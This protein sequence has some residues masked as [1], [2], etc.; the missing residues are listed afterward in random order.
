MYLPVPLVGYLCDRYKPAYVSFL[1]SLLFGSG[2][3]LAAWTYRKGPPVTVGGNGWPSAVMFLAFCG[4]GAGTVCMYLSAVTTCA[5]N[6]GRGKYKGL[7]LALP[8]AAFGLSGMWQSQVGS[9]FL[10]ERR[11]DGKRGDVDP[12]QYFI[13]LGILLSVVGVIGAV[14]LRVV[15]EEEMLEEAVEEL[16]R[17]GLLNEHDF[18]SNGTP[19]HYGSIQHV[20][21][22]GLG[23]EGSG[24]EPQVDHGEI[25]LKKAWLLNTE[26]RRFLADRTMWG[27][28]GGF[29]FA[30]GPGE[31]FILNLGT[32]IGTLY[33]PGTDP[34]TMP[35]T[36]ATHVSIVSVT[37]TLVRIVTGALSDLL[38]PTPTHVAH[39]SPALGQ[40]PKRLVV[41]RI[42]FL[43]G[44]ALVQS[45]GQVLLAS[46]LIQTHAERFW[47]V[48]VLIGS[49]Y[50]A[51]FSLTP[52]VCSVIWGVE[53]FGTN[54]GIVTMV[55]AFSATMW[56]LI[57][58]AVYQSAAVARPGPGGEGET[59]TL[60][61]GKECYAAT[62][63]AMALSIWLGCG[64]WVWAWR[65]PGGWS[66]R[67]I[68]I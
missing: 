56:N 14:F 35:T 50:G 54:W 49:G 5:K 3:F 22:P 46:G 57:Y 62:Y 47:I 65:G 15:D 68:A 17:S 58:S 30:I 38:A 12:F 61:Y 7:A 25:R 63:W 39:H 19:K 13:F 67:G 21:T 27:L 45:L 31:S 18:F 2:Y 33:P 28:A 29:F 6:F 1:A 53:N 24:S 34:S 11:Q 44:S 36:A 51:I 60:C 4:V 52:I 9:R 32:I 16:E 41:S 43:L 48:S 42:N 40:E 66:K 55:P 26:T 10:Y 64:V 20:A 23:A 8:I 37:S 59:K